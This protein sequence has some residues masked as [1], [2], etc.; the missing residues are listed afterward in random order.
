MKNWKTKTSCRYLNRWLCRRQLASLA[1][2]QWVSPFWILTRLPRAVTFN[3]FCFF[4]LTFSLYLLT[5][6][7]ILSILGTFCLLTL[8][9]SRSQF[10]LCVTSVASLQHFLQMSGILVSAFFGVGLWGEMSAGPTG[11]CEARAGLRG[12]RTIF[13]MQFCVPENIREPLALPLSPSP[14][15]GLHKKPLFLLLTWLY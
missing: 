2:N 12:S 9:F 3:H 14:S 1:D 6:C 8:E 7:S 13:G 11:V 15:L 5:Q 10:G 4:N